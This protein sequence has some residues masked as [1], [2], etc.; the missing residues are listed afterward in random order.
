M[1]TEASPRARAA[2][3]ETSPQSPQETPAEAVEAPEELPELTFDEQRFAARPS[4]LRPHARRHKEGYSPITPPFEAVGTNHAY[5]EWLEEQSMLHDAGLISRQLAGKHTMWANPYASPD[6]RAALARASVWYTAYPL[7]HITGRGQTFLAALGSEELWAAFA[8]IGIDALHTGPVKLAGGIDGWHATPSVDGHFDRISMAMDPMFGTEDEFRSLCQ[9]AARHGGTIIDDI[10][11]GHTGKGADFRLAELNYRDYPGIY[12]MVDIPEEA[13]HLL[14]D[15]PEGRDSVN[16]SPEAES[17]LADAGYII[18]ALQ[19]VI[20]FEPGVKETNWSVTPPVRD[21]LGNLK[22]WVYLHYF[23]EGQPTI[24]WL[25][26]TCAGMRLVMGDALHSLLDLG[27][28]GLRLDANG[29]LGVERSFDHSPAWSEGH[30]LSLAANQLIG[31][32]VRKVGGFTF[33][34]LNLAMDDIARTGAVGP[35]L[36]YDFV[37]RPAAWHALATGDTEFL[38]LVLRE[39]MAIGIDQASLVHALQNH[40]ELTYEL[41]HFA[42]AHRDDAYTYAGEEL[43]GVQ[44]ADRIRTELQDRLTGDAAPYNATFTQ[45]GIASTTASIIAGSL[46]ITDLDAIGDA[47]LRRITSA[48]LLLC[49]FGAWQP[50]VFALSGWDLVGALPLPRSEVSALIRGGDTRWIHRGAYDLLGEAPEARKSAAGMPRARELYGPVPRQLEQSTSFASRLAQVLKMRRRHGLATGR[51]VDVPDV[52]HRSLLV[53]VNE[54][55][56]GATQV[57]VLNFGQ[58][59][60]TARVQSDALPA[61]RVFSLETRRKVGVVDALGG[62]TVDLPAFGGHAL[63]VKD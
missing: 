60:I 5:V 21:Y 6:P 43:T 42:A 2:A 46:G 52:G 44:L 62:F 8:R 25:D 58:E 11:P 3:E 61:G 24:N 40:D 38:R 30:P 22:R 14:P 49:M 16:L 35:D 7:S 1:S 45:N 55:P 50:G 51:L 20:F 13:W 27:S 47:D 37:T 54:L 36:S 31:S 39:S 4:R 57:T 17:A 32:M 9:T 10:V 63:V 12:H 53:L 26:P 18:G 19:R 34:E 41:V 59:R 28:G 56:A 15:V 48:H 23:K 33:Q 29:F